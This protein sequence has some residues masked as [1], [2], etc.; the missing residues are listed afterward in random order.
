MSLFKNKDESR[1]SGNV[2]L[3][4]RIIQMK[5]MAVVL[6]IQSVQLTNSSFLSNPMQSS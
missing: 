4:E 6:K 1:I 5:K 2:A 3:Q